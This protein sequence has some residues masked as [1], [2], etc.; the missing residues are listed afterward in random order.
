MAHGF[1]ITIVTPLR[2]KCRFVE[3]LTGITLG[4]FFDNEGIVLYSLHYC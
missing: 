2:G 1:Q 4:I 3:S